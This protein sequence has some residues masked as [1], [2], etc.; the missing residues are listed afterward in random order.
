[1]RASL[2]RQGQS[3][4]LDCIQYNAGWL[5]DVMVR[6]VYCFIHLLYIV[7]IP[8]LG[9]IPTAGTKFCTDAVSNRGKT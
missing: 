9:H 1:M 8:Y 6:A 3:F 2:L 4:P 7:S 5:S